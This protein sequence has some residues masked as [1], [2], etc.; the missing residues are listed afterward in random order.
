MG[1]GPVPVGTG[2]SPQAPSKSRHGTVVIRYGV[3]DGSNL[4]DLAECCPVL[5]G[6]LVSASGDVIKVVLVTEADKFLIGRDGSQCDAVVT[7]SRVSRAH[8][9][10]SCPDGSPLIEDLGSMN[11]TFVNGQRIESVTP[12]SHG[13]HIKLGRTEIEFRLG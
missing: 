3:R 13:D 2:S 4:G 6:T 1:T 11:G 5:E 9:A 8:L 10:I 12:L 7:D